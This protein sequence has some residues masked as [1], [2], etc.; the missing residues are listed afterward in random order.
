MP[1]CT[2]HAIF[3][4]DRTGLT[5]EG[6]GDALLNQFDNIEFKRF[7]YPFIDTPEKAERIVAEVNKIAEGC[8]LRPIIFTSIVNEDIRHII[9]NCN[10]LHLSF[11]DAFINKLEEELGTQ[12]VLQVGRT[13]GIQD[14]ERYDARMEAVNFSLNHDDGV[15]AKDLADADVILMGVS[16][17][18]KT[19]TCLYLALQY[20]IRAANYPLT[21]DDL[22]STDLPRMVKPY[23]AKIFGLTIDPAR[24]HHIRTERRPNSQYASPENCRREVHEAESMFRQHSIPHTSTTH[25]SVEELAAGIMQACKLQRRT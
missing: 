14:T 7:T 11:F 13:H 12:A 2:R 10:G 6:M 5:A 21:P 8:N 3:I 17:S 4:S 18:G 24:L 22:D 16:R 19:P 20:G 23:K 15:S 9:R 1:P 25:K